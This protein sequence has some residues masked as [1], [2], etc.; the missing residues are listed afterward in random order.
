VRL[1][2]IALLLLTI[3]TLC[4]QVGWA[5]TAFY[6]PLR[7]VRELLGPLSANPTVVAYD[8]SWTY[9]GALTLW[10][11][12]VPEATAAVL[13]HRC[14]GPGTFEPLPRA[15]IYDVTR[16][17]PAPAADVSAC[18]LASRSSGQGVETVQLVLRGNELQLSRSVH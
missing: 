11:M 5:W 7:F 14:T 16:D 1:L 9:D 3:L 13:L 6:T 18:L 15:P 4:L 8:F 2:K 12:R 10:N 17:G